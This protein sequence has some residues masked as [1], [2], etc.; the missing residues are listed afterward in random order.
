MHCDIYFLKLIE[1]RKRQGGAL[2]RYSDSGKQIH[3]NVVSETSMTRDVNISCRFLGLD[4]TK[5]VMG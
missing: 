1:I 3:E 2:I 5:T 4:I